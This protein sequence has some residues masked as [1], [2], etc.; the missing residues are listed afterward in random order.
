[1]GGEQESISKFENSL[2]DYL[3][4]SQS[5]QF[6]DVMSFAYRYNNLK[7]YMAPSKVR[8]PHFFVRLGISE[9]CF[10]ITTSNKIDGSLGAE[11]RLVQKWANR[12]NIQRELDTYWKALTQALKNKELGLA[13]KA[14][15]PSDDGTGDVDMT[16]TGISKTKR[17]IAQERKRRLLKF[18]R[19][20]KS[21]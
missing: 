18:K 15:L 20:K 2:T 11:D 13:S 19:E 7:F 21:R 3:I 17:I 4:S 1:M 9:A 8:E 14:S 10:S 5:S 6:T 12:I 16:S